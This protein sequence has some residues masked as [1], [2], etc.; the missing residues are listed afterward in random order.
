MVAYLYLCFPIWKSILLV[1]HVI[2]FRVSYYQMSVDDSLPEK[3]KSSG[4]TVC[5]GTGSTSWFFHIN[6]ISSDDVKNI[7]DM[8]ECGASHWIS[9]SIYTAPPPHRDYVQVHVSALLV[10][11]L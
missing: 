9:I 7:L 1:M 5:T 6:H 2:C 4:V 11:E 10:E 3:Q 8:G